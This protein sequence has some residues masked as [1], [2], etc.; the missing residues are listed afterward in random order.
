[1]VPSDSDDEAPPGGYYVFEGPERPNF[2]PT[3][4]PPLP[5]NLIPPPP[6]HPSQNLLANVVEP[7]DSD[8]DAPPGGYEVRMGDPAKGRAAFL[9]RSKTRSTRSPSGTTEA[10]LSRRKT[11]PAGRGGEPSKPRRGV[12]EAP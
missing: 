5:L 3:S 1:M 6:R 9:A 8:E 10:S 7:S 4:V 12:K 2:L 11:A